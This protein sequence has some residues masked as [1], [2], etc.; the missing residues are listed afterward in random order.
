VQRICVFCGSQTGNEPVYADV[1]ARVGRELAARG[2]GLVYGGGGIG[3]MGIVADAVLEAGGEVIGVIPDGLAVQEVMHHG[4]LDMRVVA[5]MHERKALMHS[6]SDA[7][8]ALPGGVGTY[9]ELFEVL[10]WRQLK[11]HAKPI[12][13]LDVA[14]FFEPFVQVIEMSVVEGFMKPKN[15]QLFVHGTEPAE[16]LD[17]LTAAMEAV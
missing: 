16:L 14:G 7:Y 15:R 2:I 12:G 4:V 17:S 11:I 3:L 5:G 9:E 10:A 13:V 6:L 8:L 1:A